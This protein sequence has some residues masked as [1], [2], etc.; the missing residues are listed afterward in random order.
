MTNDGERRGILWRA[1]IRPLGRLLKLGV[2]VAA[3]P[4][5]A[6]LAM[7]ARFLPKRVDVGLGPEPMINNVYH[8]LALVNAGYSAET[9]VLAVYYIT[10]RFDYRADLVLPRPLGFLRGFLL[11]A[12]AV[13]RYK[14]L[15]I[16]FNGGPL[17][18]YPLIWR[19][20]PLL[21]SLAGVRTVVM[22]YGGDVQDLTRSDNL[23]FKH[24]QSR[25]YPG[26]RL[27]RQ[28]VAEQVDLWTKNGDHIISGVEWV[29]YMYHWDTLMLGHFSIDA[30]EWEAELGPAEDG[31]LRILHAPNHKSIKGTDYF[32]S[33][34]E[35]LQQE[36]YSVEMD[37]VQRVSNEEIRRRMHLADVVADQLVVGWYA[38]FAIEAMAMGKPVLCYLRPDLVDFYTAAGLCRPNEIPLINCTPLTV[39]EEIRRLCVDRDR[40]RRTGE[41]GVQYVHEHHS[42]QHVGAVFSQINS[43]L[44]VEP[45]S[46]ESDHS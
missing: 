46:Q 39:K 45:S 1:T 30:A 11:F 18:I 10:D 27:R 4:F 36:G 19:L 21:L 31:P 29:D 41:A 5:L 17:M 34:V 42:L 37:L 44:G 7:T 8:K 40:L 13:F 32:V 35:E 24:A 25:D 23:L 12:R 15:Y 14:V 3:L 38:M 9:F 43:Q 2:A 16:Y 28:R 6:L 20:E 22:P 33:A 26:Y